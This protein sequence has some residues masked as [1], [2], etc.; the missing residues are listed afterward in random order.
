MIMMISDRI[1]GR[2]D[3]SPLGYVAL[4]AAM[5]VLAWVIAG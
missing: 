2:A 3:I 4:F 5:F 1:D